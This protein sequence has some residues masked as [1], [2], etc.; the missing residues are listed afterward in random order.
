[1]NPDK[2]FEQN[3]KQL[4]RLLK[5]ILGQQSFQSKPKDLM[6][7][8]KDKETD[9]NIFFLNFPMLSEEGIEEI[10]E[11]LGQ[12]FLHDGLEDGELKYEINAVDQEFLRRHGIRF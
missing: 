12:T 6:N 4:M 9:I 1:M 7:L 8:L 11:V 3:I 2:D 5:K 10:E